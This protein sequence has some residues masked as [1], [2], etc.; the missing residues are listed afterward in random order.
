MFS[1]F[2]INRPIFAS[3][4]A[5]LIVVAG[6]VS[7][8][9]LPVA[10]YPDITPPM[11]QVTANYPGAD[12][13]VVADTVAQPIEEQVNGV[14][15]MLYMSSTS[16]SDGSYTLQ[17]TFDLGTDIDMASVLVQN[18][19]AW[20][21]A[22]LPEEVQ[23]QGVTTKKAST[24]LVTVL[25]VYSPDKRYD[26]LYLTN[27]VTIRIKDQL[28]R[29]N[30]V[31]AVNVY[32]SK[33]YSLRIWLDPNK[34]K[35]RDIT[36]NDVV[37]AVKQ[38]NVQVAAGQLGQP[39][40]PPG[41]DFQL[42]VNTLGRLSD[43]KQF[44]NIIVKAA[45][46]KRITRVKDVA[47]AELGGQ[48]YSTFS[49]LNGVPAATIVVY[50][51][52]GSNALQVA[53]KV[54][55]VMEKL[56]KRFPQGLDYKVVYNTADFVRASIHE[57]VATLFIAFI[58]VFIVVYIFLQDWRA[59]LVPAVTIPVSIIGTFSVM[60]LFGFSINM[61]TLFGLVLAIG[62]VVD[63]AIVVVENVERN[64]REFG[65]SAKD[66]ALRAMSE[67]SGAILG[68]TLVLMAVFIPAAFMGGIS[69]QL[70]RQ[71]SVTIAASTFFSA[72]NALTLSPA[73]CALVVR[74]H[75][76]KRNVFFRAFNTGF[77]KFTGYYTRL[78][79]LA[80]RRVALMLVLFGGLLAVTYFGFTS[81]PTGFIPAE[82]DGLVLLN[83]QMPDGA[84][85][86]RTRA[87]SVRLGEILKNTEGIADSSVLGGFSI[88]DGASPNFGLGFA[89][90]TPWDERLKKGRSKTVIMEELAAK[91]AKI[92][93]GIVMAFSLPPI[94]GLGS[95]G[96]FQMEVQDLGDSGL[97]SLQKATDTLCET[98]ATQ[99]SLAATFS[100][101]RANTPT[102]FADVDR[103]KALELGVPLQSVFDTLQT[104]LGSTYVN[105]F[106]KFSRTWQVNVQAAGKYRTKP[107]DIKRLWVRNKK[108]EMVP[109]GTL[110]KV[111]DALGPQRI[112]RYNMFPAAAINGIPA[113]G[114]S[115][116][117]A[118]N[119]MED[120]AKAK[121]PSTMGFE[122]TG[123]AYQEKAA[124]GK[125]GIV[126]GL[127][128]LV[129]MLI[130]SA[131]YES[132]ADPLA[133]IL[134]VPL[135]VLGAVVA[136]MSRH[137]DNNLYTQVG[138]VLLVGLSAKNAI[139]IVEFARDMRAQGKGVLEGAVEGAKLRFRPIL[140]TS[141]AFIMG[142]LPLVIATGAGAASR[143][144][145]GTAVFGGMIGV[146]ILSV[147][148]TPVLYVMVQE[149]S[150]WLRRIAGSRSTPPADGAEAG[151]Q[152]E[153]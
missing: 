142:V 152:A 46:G 88:I 131:Q 32:P 76:G 3:V 37:N 114:V 112:V 22:Q 105:D 82:D 148:F 70:Y 30:G 132:W 79:S 35:Y 62:I 138:L 56:K 4:I 137:M 84:S 93:E 23:R 134:I 19:V 67:I 115:S 127:A 75:Q 136:V 74:P 128:V 64:M 141:F 104:Y 135:G 89:A 38:Q 9:S 118:L 113:P 78:V 65:L 145:L 97:D 117:Q 59:T 31:G 12:P 92:Q 91:F 36:T 60:A 61:V 18:R 106:N 102:I 125:A 100:T 77:D 24:T 34:L 16:A 95:S 90:L 55:A 10:Q 144:A 99:A 153:T 8:V 140:M 42:S 108:L 13:Q 17:I 116:G 130:L 28:S 14:E 1:R 126:F 80:V 98:A 40:A 119:I 73:L 29:I 41:Q 5:I 54:N 109:L 66:A 47:A 69:G 43:V 122:W 6:V 71:F 72:L 101:F 81:I 15:N 20:A 103:T 11:V 121:L 86:Q 7:L 53:D 51:E 27:Y 124:A 151:E 50:Q 107:E 85:L 39:P 149:V 2:F 33:D 120:L 68:I 150:E 25:C 58:L 63:D 26:D 146:M 139:L 111:E 96:G 110:V 48:Q 57:V 87:L 133:V 21:L 94:P 129:I 52:P 83:V 44:E 45:E 49:Y 147:I 143:Q 123:M